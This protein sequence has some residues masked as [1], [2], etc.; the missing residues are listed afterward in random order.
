MDTEF[1][2][3]DDVDL[4][5][6][7]SAAHEMQGPLSRL[8]AAL[9]DHAQGAP[10]TR[11]D[12]ELRLAERVTA[13]VRGVADMTA[14]ANASARPMD[15]HEAVELALQLTW[16]EVATHA[17]VTRRYRAIPRARGSVTMVARA[18]VALLR[19]AA[20]AIP[21]VLPGANRI[22]V[23]T[24]LQ[25][26]GLVY[27]DVIDTGVGI[28]PGDMP[29]VFEPFFTTKGPASAGLGLTAARAAIQGLGG[30]IVA[31]SQPGY[32]SRF[33]ILLMADE[34]TSPSIFS[35]SRTE[36][37]PL[38]RVLLVAANLE[39]TRE[40]AAMFESEDTQMTLADGEDALERLGLG[41]PFELVVWDA[42]SWGA[43]GYRQRL[44]AIA[45]DALSRTFALA[46][47]RH[48]PHPHRAAG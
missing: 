20:Q 19:N 12:E 17:C 6:A 7:T 47:A 44:A 39:Q 9:R 48:A 27:V 30:T 10:D 46:T 22:A 42:E 2:A 1:V 26:D 25:E 41:E 24:G 16:G 32:G 13:I 36:A 35:S 34:T 23:D 21:S 38:R 11:F 45:P 8:I 31:Q 40:L 28:E 15:V 5:L 33:R 18:L 43:G 14:G 4:S 3:D 29:Y 37:S